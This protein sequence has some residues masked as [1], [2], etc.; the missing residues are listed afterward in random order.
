MDIK[1]FMNLYKEFLLQCE[2]KG[3]LVEVLVKRFGNHLA[4]ITSQ[5][6]IEV[7]FFFELDLENVEKLTEKTNQSI[8]KYGV[9]RQKGKGDIFGKE[10]LEHFHSHLAKHSPKK[11][12]SK[13]IFYNPK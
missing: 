7:Q 5:E 6:G 11:R 2:Q 9:I 4:A 12:N 1:T 10:V 8:L 3:W 13:L